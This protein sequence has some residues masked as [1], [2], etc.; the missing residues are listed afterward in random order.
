MHRFVLITLLLVW[1]ATAEAAERIISLKPNITEIV[2][3][4]G[5]GDRVVGVTSWC[6]FPHAA[7]KLP[8]VADYLRPNVEAVLALKPDLIIASK[9]NG[10][11]RPIERL[12]AHGIA[13]LL[14][15][16]SGIAQTLDAI[17]EIGEAV[18]QSKEAAQL[19]AGLR[20]TFAET[21]AQ[22]T[23]PPKRVLLLVGKNPWV[24][25][26]P[27]SFFGQLLEAAGGVNV[28]TAPKP[29]YPYLSLERIIAAQADVIVDASGKMGGKPAGLPRPLRGLAMTPIDLEL[30][31]AGPR[32]GEGMRAL[33]EAIIE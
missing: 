22:V 7:T 29:A 24:A 3:A 30:L 27:K 21:V 16:F 8:K 6:N 9:E 19:V 14:V 12:R 4:L 23:A 26:G 17:E 31:R 1:P 20:A 32:I 18:G 2:F 10:L 28:I 11:R 13:V 25:A 15:E 33:R 5:A